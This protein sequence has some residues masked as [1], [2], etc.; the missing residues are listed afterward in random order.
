MMASAKWVTLVC[1]IFMLALGI[2]RLYVGL[3]ISGV[4]DY[5]GLRYGYVSGYWITGFGL[6]IAAFWAYLIALERRRGR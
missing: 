5:D 1:A 6:A 2:W 4:A 3:G